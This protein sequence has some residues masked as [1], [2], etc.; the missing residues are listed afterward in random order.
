MA[1]HPTIDYDNIYPTNT[2]KKALI[3]ALVFAPF[4][5]A[6]AD[7]ITLPNEPDVC[8]N[9]EGHQYPA[10]EGYHAEADGTCTLLQEPVHIDIVPPGGEPQNIDVTPP[11]SDS[12]VIDVNPVN[13]GG[14]DG[15]TITT[16]EELQNYVFGANTTQQERSALVGSRRRAASSGGIVLGASTTSTEQ[17]MMDLQV[18]VID[19]LVQVVEQLQAQL[20]IQ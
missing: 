5:T 18:Q 6:H 19:L 1:L 13:P 15:G 16:I 2:M 3:L 7:L 20:K 9:I 12:Q 11:G 8:S 17:Q 10:P 4:L 14:T